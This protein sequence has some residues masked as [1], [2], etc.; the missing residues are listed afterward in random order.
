M[1][2]R[3]ELRGRSVTYDQRNPKPMRAPQPQT[4]I[5]EHLSIED[6]ADPAETS[7][8]PLATGSN[9]SESQ[10]QLVTP[11]SQASTSLSGP[12]AAEPTSPAPSRRSQSLSTN[13]PSLSPLIFPRD[14]E[15]THL[16][17]LVLP[18]LPLPTTPTTNEDHNASL[19]D[20]II[21]P[22]QHPRTAPRPPA[23]KAEPG[24]DPGLSGI[25]RSRCCPNRE[26]ARQCWR[27]PTLTP[28]TLLI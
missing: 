2:L 28:S 20:D 22:S 4:N 14:T 27:S 5:Y 19:E 18:S 9:W 23:P 11:S 7:F 17:V 15:R 8:D 10:I 26:R 21:P 6:I 16:P 25:A 1:A 24:T 12:T 3:K 13:L